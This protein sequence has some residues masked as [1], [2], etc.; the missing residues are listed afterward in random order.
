MSEAM[1]IKTRIC[2]AIIF[3][4]SLEILMAQ[5]PTGDSSETEVPIAGIEFLIGSGMLF[6]IVMIMKSTSKGTKR[7]Q[8]PK[9]TK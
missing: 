9:S 4:L 5:P 8:L 3:L 6:G 2:L 1:K 7:H